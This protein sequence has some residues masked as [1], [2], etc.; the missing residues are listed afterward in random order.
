MCLYSCL[1]RWRR[2]SPHYALTRGAEPSLS[3]PGEP[4]ALSGYRPDG[5]RLSE[6]HPGKDWQARPV[7]KGADTQSGGAITGL[8]GRSSNSDRSSGMTIV[9][10]LSAFGRNSDRLDWQWAVRTADVQVCST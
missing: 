4:N 8:K 2:G 10:N 3:T 6:G 1:C 5:R 7:C 9:D